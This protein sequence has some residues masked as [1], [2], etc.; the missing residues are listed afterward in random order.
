MF[1]YVLAWDATSDIIEDW[2]YDSLAKEYLLKD[3]VREWM[4][5]ANPYAVH[6]MLEILMEAMDRGMWNPSEEM[7][8]SLEKLYLENEE[9]L[10]GIS[11]R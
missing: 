3:D 6:D 7:L 8:R 2:M 9:L 4:Q 1:E 5:D 10:E 11:D